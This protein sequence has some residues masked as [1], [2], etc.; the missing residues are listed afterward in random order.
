MEESKTISPDTDGFNIPVSTTP[1]TIAPT[2]VS[3]FTSSSVNSSNPSFDTLAS[4]TIDSTPPTTNPIP[5]LDMHRDQPPMPEHDSTQPK[6]SAPI[7]GQNY[8][9]KSSKSMTIILA[10]IIILLVV[11]G[12]YGVYIW[13]HK[14]VTQANS[15]N[16]SLNSEVASLQAELSA[17]DKNLATAQAALSNP[18][19]NF[20]TLGISL[21]VPSSLKDLTWTANTNPTK[22]TVSGA[23]VTPT[24]ANLS[25]TSLAALDSAC[26][27]TNGALGILSKTTGQYPA[28]P[29]TANSSGT[30]VEQFSSYYI[31]YS[32]PV[33]CSKTAS[34]NT[35]QTS[36]VSSLKTT[37]TKANITVL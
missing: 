33:A 8:S 20:T 34:T 23:S 27:T 1:T 28:T 16:T 25:S 36:L 35:T 13:Q 4:S 11:G 3:D 9:N 32:A 14:K 12:V 37:L 30:L 18:T 6:L 19:I 5:G 26:S 21:S 7:H 24:E 17:A 2:T 29:T 15:L 31:A 10:V 22:L